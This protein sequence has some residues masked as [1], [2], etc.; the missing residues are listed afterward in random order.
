MHTVN[1]LLKPGEEKHAVGMPIQ[2]ELSIFSSHNWR[3]SGLAPPNEIDC[4]YDLD[5]DPD[6]WL[7]SG[8]R[9]A[10]FTAQVA[11]PLILRLIM[12]GWIDKYV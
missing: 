8:C 7:I 12:L 3:L 5:F 11:H 6:T 1:L 9:R 10:Q 2:A 4:F